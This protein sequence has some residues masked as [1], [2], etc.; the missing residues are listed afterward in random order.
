MNDWPDSIAD[1]LDDLIRRGERGELHDAQG[2]PPLATFDFDNTCIEGDIGEAVHYDLAERFHYALDDPAFW[3]VID[4]EQGGLDLA[5][6]WEQLRDLTP[7]E[8][9]TSE[10]AARFA[11]DIIATYSRRY[12]RLGARDAYTWACRLHVGLSPDFLR[13]HGH[14]LFLQEL[15]RPIERQ[16]RQA[17]C[18]MEVTLH[19]G[20]RVRPALHR[21]IRQLQST[22][23]DVWVISATNQWTVDAVAPTFGISPNKVVGNRC[24]VVDDR[25]TDRR[26]GPTTWRQGKVDAIDTFIGRRPVFAIGD[27]WTDLEMLDAASELA[28][29]IDRGD[30]KLQAEA[31]ARGWLRAPSEGFRTSAHPP[32]AA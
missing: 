24:A 15:Q 32:S 2:R 29:L 14:H 17:S 27:T 7:A 31:D 13:R 1:A 10:E 21:L 23:F 4:E 11:N 12:Q 28:I 25:I 19:R 16:V 3:S 18:G 22:G 9:A 20:V 5:R 6:T 8:R 26:E 30:P